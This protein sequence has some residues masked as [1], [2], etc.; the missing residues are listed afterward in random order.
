MAQEHRVTIWDESADADGNLGPVYGAQWCAWRTADGRTVNQFD[1]LV[2]RDSQEPG[3]PAIN[4]QR[5][6]CW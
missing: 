5:V 3:Q 1:Q 6:E 4:R 2:E